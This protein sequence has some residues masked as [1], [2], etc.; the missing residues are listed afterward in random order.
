MYGT[1]VYILY[2]RIYIRLAFH[3]VIKVESFNLTINMYKYYIHNVIITFLFSSLS[4]NLNKA[5]K[6]KN[7]KKKKKRKVLFVISIEL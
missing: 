7:I 4:L 5:Y 1:R 6:I 3:V 2:Q